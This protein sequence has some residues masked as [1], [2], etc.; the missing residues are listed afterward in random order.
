MVYADKTKV[1]YVLLLGEDEIT[2]GRVSLKNM[3]TGEQELLPLE[4]AAEKIL[5]F[6]G[7][8]LAIPPIKE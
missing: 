8:A 6:V 3:I 1:P 2:A 5:Q 7:K 4:A